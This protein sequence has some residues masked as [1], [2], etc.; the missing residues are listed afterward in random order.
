MDLRLI[1]LRDYHDRR[2]RKKAEKEEQC[3]GWRKWP[4]MLSTTETPCTETELI[5]LRLLVAGKNCREE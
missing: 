4:V 2:E 5:G 1:D 3:L